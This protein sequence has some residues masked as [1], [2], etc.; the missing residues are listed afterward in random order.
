MNPWCF[1]DLELAGNSFGSA[2]WLKKFWKD[3]LV[4]FPPHVG[5]QDAFD[6][7]FQNMFQKSPWQW[8]WNPAF[9]LRVVLLQLQ[10]L[11]RLGW[12]SGA[13]LVMKDRNLKENGNMFLLDDMSYDMYWCVTSYLQLPNFSIILVCFYTTCW[14]QQIA[15][16]G[17]I[18]QVLPWPHRLHFFRQMNLHRKLNH[19]V[20]VSALHPNGIY[21][22]FILGIM[23]KPKEQ[24][25]G[26]QWAWR[27]DHEQPRGS[28]VRHERHGIFLSF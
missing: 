7:F 28:L 22:M 15:I 12:I 18:L 24:T 2:W 8:G 14:N 5:F 9:S 19:I 20:F 26:P 6:V 21:A 16:R 27:D 13:Q 1:A 25:S 23:G 3:P 10:A 4:F 11:M 17:M